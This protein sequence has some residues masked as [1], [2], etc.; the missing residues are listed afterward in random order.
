MKGDYLDRLARKHGGLQGLAR[1]LG[2]YGPSTP[3]KTVTNDNV[4][5][6][7]SELQRRIIHKAAL[8]IAGMLFRLSK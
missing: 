4:P 5:A 6:R 2:Q 8:F 7:R 3:Y 1:E